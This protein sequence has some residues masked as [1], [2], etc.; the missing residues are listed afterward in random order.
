M[1]KLIEVYER[2]LAHFGPQGWWP[3]ATPFE[4]LVGAILTQRTTWGNAARA[5]E[6]LKQAGLLEPAALASASAEE[7][8]ALIRVA[9]FFR[10][11]A[12]R[13]VTIARTLVDQYNGSMER[14]FGKT[15]TGELRRELLSSRGVGPETADAVL[16]YAASRLVFPIDLYTI[17]L[18]ERLGLGTGGYSELQ[19]LFTSQLPAD[20]ELYKEFHALIDELGKNFCRATPRCG[21][22][23]LREVCRY[24]S[25]T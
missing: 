8:A 11:K 24:A 15:D 17:R 10:Q 19:R 12:E 23:P 25:S 7:V 5:I 14:M 1:L 16:L 2:L 20:L 9:G 18:A 22:C 6:N 13:L 3:V 21:R 4:V